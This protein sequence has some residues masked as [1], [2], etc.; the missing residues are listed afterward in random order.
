MRGSLL[1]RQWQKKRI[2]NLPTP[3]ASEYKDC[4]PVGSKSHTHMEK[5][6][7]LCAVVKSNPIQ[8]PT[9]TT[10]DSGHPLP[11]R[12]KNLSGGQ[13][14]PLVSV[15]GGKLNPHFVEWMMGYPQDWTKVGLKELSNSEIL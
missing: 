12:K 5:K 6:Q 1:W 3:R 13:K 15:I 14:P 8:L 7:Y 4:G 9:P 10:F 11:P 2:L